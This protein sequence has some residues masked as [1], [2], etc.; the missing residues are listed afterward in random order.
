[1][2]ASAGA[3]G[4]VSAARARALGDRLQPVRSAREDQ[5]F[6]YRDRVTLNARWDAAPG[7]RFG[8]MR[9]DELIP[10]H[11]CP[12]HT[13][14]V[15]ALVALLRTTLPPHANLPLAYLH[16]AGGQATLIVKARNHEPACLDA[17]RAG[18]PR[19]ASKDCG[20]IAMPRPAAG[21]SR[22]GAGPGLGRADSLDAAG[23]VHG[24]AAFQQLLPDLHAQAV[25]LAR[26][27]SRAG[28]RRRRC[29]TCTAASARR[30]GA[31]VQ[32]G[33]A[34]LGI[35][36]AGGAVDCA[37]S[38]RRV[39]SCC[40]ARAN[41]ACRRS[42]NGGTTAH[43]PAAPATSIRRAR[44]SSRRCSRRWRTSCGRSGWPI[45]RAVPGRWRGIS[46]CSRR[47]V[48]RCVRSTVRLLSRHA[49]RRVPG[50]AHA[51]PV[52]PRQSMPG[53]QRSRRGCRDRPGTGSTGWSLPVRRRPS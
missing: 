4:R 7:W 34:V 23:C 13:P 29:W 46:P 24:P 45:F 47:R 28:P 50:P 1:M 39:P 19:P 5:R 44:V 8:L 25:A 17:L 43:S 26:A 35:E 16:V 12:V 48:T 36:L 6:G 37:R 3:K 10:I 15:N 20:C 32:A 11:D 30:C 14:R 27:S 31:G 42:A 40:A 53:S 38:M 9:R 2:A 49:S 52:N 22:A 18:C 33:A 41:S 51:R 21:C